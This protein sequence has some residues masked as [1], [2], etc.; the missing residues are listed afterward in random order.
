MP[1]LQRYPGQYRGDADR[2]L[3]S[4]SAAVIDLSH[5]IGTGL[6][7]RRDGQV[8]S[9][10]L[11]LV[12][13]VLRGLGTPG[14]LNKR[15]DPG[16]LLDA[17]AEMMQMAR[18]IKGNGRMPSLKQS[19]LKNPARMGRRGYASS[20]FCCLTPRQMR[21]CSP[22]R[23]GTNGKGFLVRPAEATPDSGSDRRRRRP[24]GGSRS[25]PM[26]HD[27]EDPDGIDLAR[28]AGKYG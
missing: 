9:R 8:S 25:L 26:E 23:L 17:Y 22:G 15:G 6:A 16:W 11:A 1:V 7:W 28:P 12:R 4:S 2:G 3:K 20:R 13:A 10:R 21:I 14:T 18:S 5:W 24:A 19:M 27:D